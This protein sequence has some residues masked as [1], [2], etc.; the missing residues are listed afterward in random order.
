MNTAVCPGEKSDFHQVLVTEGYGQIFSGKL[1]FCNEDSI[2]ID[3][4]CFY[5]KIILQISL[6]GSPVCCR[7]FT[8][9]VFCTGEIHS[10]S[11]D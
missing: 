4:N 2:I 8:C 5:V 9:E 10:L 7:G 1:E 11:G 3:G 6:W